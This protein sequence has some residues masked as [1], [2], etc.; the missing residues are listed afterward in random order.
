MGKRARNGALLQAVADAL[1]ACE[2]AGIPAKLRHGIVMTHAGYVLPGARGWVAR[3]L[4]Y[5]PFTPADD[6][7]EED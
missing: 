7:P 2:K 1:N 3:T 4:L 5:S 6:D